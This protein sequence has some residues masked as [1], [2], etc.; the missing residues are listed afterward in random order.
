[1]I[2]IIF[3]VNNYIKFLDCVQNGNF[4]NF[5]STL[6]MTRMMVLPSLLEGSISRATWGTLPFPRVTL[7]E[8]KGSLGRGIPGSPRNWPQIIIGHPMRG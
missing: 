5:V 2:S 7:N 3:L 1:M 6:L 8:G 4:T